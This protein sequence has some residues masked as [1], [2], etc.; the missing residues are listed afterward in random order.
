MRSDKLPLTLVI[1]SNQ[2]GATMTIENIRD[3]FYPGM[4]LKTM[5][6]KSSAGILPR[7]AGFVYDTRDVVQWWDVQCETAER[8]A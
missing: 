7:R 2:Y 5:Q 3:V 6:N 4:T 1:L 8:C